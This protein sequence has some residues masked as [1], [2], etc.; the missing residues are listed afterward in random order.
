VTGPVTASR[1]IRRYA[2]VPSPRVRLICLPYAGGSASLFRSWRL[3]AELAAEVLAVQ[4]PG[5]ENRAGEPPVRR[6]EPVVRALAGELAPLLDRPFAFFG[7]SMGAL[8]AF[9]LARVLRQ[10][11]GPAPA[12]L[13]VSAHRAPDLPNRHPGISTLPDAEFVA[14]MDELAGPSPSAVRSSEL[15][16][17]LAPTTRADF[18][19]CEHYAY[20]PGEPLDTPVTCFTAVDDPQVDEAESAAWRRHTTGPFRLHRLTGGHLFVRDHAPAVLAHVAGGLRDAATRRAL[21]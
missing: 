18:E 11:G 1:W 7:H 20:R 3:P 9:E 19:L 6:L 10:G 5:R 15:L 8:L 17:L 4:L 13:Y 12:H 2:G 14:R 16:L 21:P